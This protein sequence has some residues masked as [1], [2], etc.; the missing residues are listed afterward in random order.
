MSL[1]KYSFVFDICRWHWETRYAKEREGWGVSCCY[2][3]RKI[4]R[5]PGMSVYYCA[6]GVGI[7][8]IL[9]DFISVFHFVCLFLNLWI[10]FF[11]QRVITEQKSFINFYSKLTGISLCRDDA[12]LD[13]DL[14][15]SFLCT[16][17]PTDDKTHCKWLEN[18][19]STNRY[20][21]VY[22]WLLAGHLFLVSLLFVLLLSVCTSHSLLNPH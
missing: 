21:N 7:I 5:S 1:T 6:C 2:I 22:S 9:K 4:Q 16:Y 8:R 17:Y 3:G 19:L 11:C 15:D 14:L 13:T 12:S 10:Y 20:S 18:T